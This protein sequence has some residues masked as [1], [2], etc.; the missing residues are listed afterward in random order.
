MFLLEKRCGGPFEAFSCLGLE[1]VDLLFVHGRTSPKAER[2]QMSNI[3]QNPT[4]APTFYNDIKSF[5]LEN[6]SVAE[7]GQ[8]G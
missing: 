3:L 6:E 4:D 5:Y 2:M 1:A 7:D 8:L